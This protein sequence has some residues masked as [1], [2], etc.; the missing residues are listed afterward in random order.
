MSYRDFASLDHI[1]SLSPGALRSL[2]ARA[3]RAHD[4]GALRAVRAELRRR[5]AVAAP[6]FD[7]YAIEGT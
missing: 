2:A 7:S 5:R 3:H 4:H 6:G 1:T